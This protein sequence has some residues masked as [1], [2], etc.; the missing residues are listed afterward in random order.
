MLQATTG[1]MVCG[2]D[3]IL[4]TPSIA[5]WGDIMLRKK[6]IIDKNNQLENKNRKRH[7]YRILHKVLLHNQKQ[8]K[9]EKTYV[10]PY[11]IT[12]VWTNEN[13]AMHWV[14]VQERINIRWIIPY[15]E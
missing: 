15:H 8:N 1:H 13:F 5:D 11:L 12:Q 7:T 2:R 6:K 9:Y 10:G 3:M 14:A 4:N